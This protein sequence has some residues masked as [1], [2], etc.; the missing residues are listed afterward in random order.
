LIDDIIPEPPGGA[1]EDTDAAAEILKIHLL[2]HLD[3]L[4]ILS[5]AE[6][7]DHRYTKFRQMGN[8]FV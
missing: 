2:R 8:F 7:I 1:H 3:R 5:A 4:S 6:L